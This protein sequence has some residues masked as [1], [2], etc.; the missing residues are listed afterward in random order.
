MEEKEKEELSVPTPADIHPVKEVK[1]VD[2]DGKEEKVKASL[3]SSNS[4]NENHA[5]E[6]TF[7]QERVTEIAAAAYKRG[8]SSKKVKDLEEENG[9]LKAEL[10]SLKHENHVS[11][12]ASKY[13]VSASLLKTTKLKGEDL[14]SYAESLASEQKQLKDQQAA[15][16]TAVREAVENQSTQRDAWAVLAAAL[17]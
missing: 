15:G 9:R 16:Y 5:E 3:N 14:D 11:A 4:I 8:A 12:L 1:I 13:G 17:K 6:K 7:S 10:E 2:E